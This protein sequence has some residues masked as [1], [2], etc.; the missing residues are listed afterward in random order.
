MAARFYAR[1]KL[2]HCT[3]RT[4]AGA[5]DVYGAAL[6]DPQDRA[7]ERLY[8]SQSQRQRCRTFSFF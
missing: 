2:R 7:W 4:A 6:G 1:L 3:S 5:F 8:A